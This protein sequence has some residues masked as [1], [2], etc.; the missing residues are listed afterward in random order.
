MRLWCARADAVE[1]IFQFSMVTWS[2]SPSSSLARLEVIKSISP[3]KG[4]LAR[5][6]DDAEVVLGDGAER[7]EL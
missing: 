1:S 5:G 7:V 6:G 3:S 2:C 4:A